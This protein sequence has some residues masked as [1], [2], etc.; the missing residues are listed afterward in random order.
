MDA[1]S[2]DDFQFFEV[3]L[4]SAEEAHPGSKKFYNNGIAAMLLHS[5]KQRDYGRDH[6]PFSNVRASEEWGVPGWVGCMIRA[7]DK[8]RRLQTFAAKGN[9]ANES[10][11]DSFLD[12]AVYS[13]IGLTLYEEQLSQ[14]SVSAHSEPSNPFQQP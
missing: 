4:D 11:R 9:L 10:V 12:L 13:L 14:E 3:L 2:S 5:Q 1:L 7:N 6:D 8:I